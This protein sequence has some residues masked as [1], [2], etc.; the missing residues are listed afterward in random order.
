MTTKRINRRKNNSVLQNDSLGLGAP[1][2]TAE[3]EDEDEDD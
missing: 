3:D 2:I 1:V